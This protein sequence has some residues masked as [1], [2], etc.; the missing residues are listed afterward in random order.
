M[1]REGGWEWAETSHAD[2]GFDVPGGVDDVR[3]M[4]GSWKGN[5]WV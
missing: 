4:C 3:A 5:E 2:V 1:A